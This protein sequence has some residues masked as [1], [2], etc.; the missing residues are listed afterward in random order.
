MF[1]CGA[2]WRGRISAITDLHFGREDLI[3][4]LFLFAKPKPIGGDG[5]MRLKIQVA[6]CGGF[7]GIGRRTEF[8]RMQWCDEHFKDI[9]RPVARFPADDAGLPWLQQ[10]KEPMQFLAACYELVDALEVGTTFE[11]RLPCTIDATASGYQHLALMRAA[12]EEAALVNLMPNMPPQDF[13]GRV[14]DE[15]LTLLKNEHTDVERALF[16]DRLLS[17]HKRAGSDLAP[18]LDR[19]FVK[20]N[21]MTKVYGAQEDGAMSD[22]N[23]ESLKELMEA[24][25]D[26]IECVDVSRDRLETKLRW[27]KLVSKHTWIKV[28]RVGAPPCRMR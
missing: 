14:A 19:N 3:R 13:Y 21:T 5:I 16:A 9:V 1:A 2:T 27:A 28:Q 22:Q 10:A 15:V 12:Q 7:D 11:T 4:G 20:P 6:T 25:F 24:E 8:E 23:F 18:L 26:A 17:L